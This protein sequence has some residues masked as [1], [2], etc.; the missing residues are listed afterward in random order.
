M[1]LWLLRPANENDRRWG[2]DCNYGFV[3]R[4]ETE[5]RAR[6]MANAQGADENGL[7]QVHKNLAVWL[8]P[9]ATSC[10]EVTV[11]GPE[12]TIIVDFNAG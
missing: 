8:D 1:K 4:A 9:E 12:A 10:T 11:D 3:I 2:Y 7:C 5:Q 6:E